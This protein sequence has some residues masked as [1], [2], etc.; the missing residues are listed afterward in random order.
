MSRFSMS[1]E[2]LEAR[3][4]LTAVLPGDPTQPVDAPPGDVP[5]DSQPLDPTG[6]EVAV[7]IYTINKSA[8]PS[9]GVTLKETVNHKFTAKLGEFTFKTVDEALNAVINWGDG[10]HSAGKLVGSYATG[11]YYVQGT[12]TY[13]H[14]DTYAVDVKIFARPIGSPVTPSSPVAEFGATIKA[15]AATP[16]GVSLTE[17]A[18]RKF[19]AKLGEFTF[20]T[21]DQLLSADVNWGDGKHSAGKLVGSY[22][23]GQYYVEGTHTYSHAGTFKVHVTIFASL[24]G[25]P[26]LP[27]FAVDDFFAT[28]KVMGNA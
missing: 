24:A 4:L 8:Q 11:K 7:P 16:T 5:V 15:K 20:R 6:G 28:I 25:S 18:Q 2:A 26:N 9:S 17:V 13:T 23:T 19:T 3:R 1:F 10:T 12:H 14:A 22:A 27:K 21:V